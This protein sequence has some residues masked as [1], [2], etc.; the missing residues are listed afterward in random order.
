M[1]TFKNKLTWAKLNLFEGEKKVSKN[2][3]MTIVFSTFK[4][5]NT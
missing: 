2:E 1:F 4:S 3:K 5:I